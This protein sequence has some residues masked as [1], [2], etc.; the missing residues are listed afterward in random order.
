MKKN[1]L[2]ELQEQKLLHIE[3][4]GYWIAFYGSIILLGIQM[5]F[6]SDL[7]AVVSTWIMFMTHALYVSISCKKEGIWDRK[8][9][10][11]KKTIAMSSLTSAISVAILKFILDLKGGYLT[12]KTYIFMLVL[13]VITF[14]MAYGAM[15][16]SAKSIK[17][18]QAEL[19]AEPDDTM[20]E[21]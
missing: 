13:F 7:V 11:S 20:K 21:E 6:V 1:N 17:K 15:S 19:N 18:R 9:D 12:Y 10:M 8:Q 2:D 4:K 14:L 3:S 5:I 16:L